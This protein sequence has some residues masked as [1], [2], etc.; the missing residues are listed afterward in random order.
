VAARRIAAQ[1]P[2]PERWHALTAWQLTAAPPGAD[3]GG[4]NPL[5]LVA[6]LFLSLAALVLLLACANLAN[7]LLARG[8]LRR[9][10][11]AVRA[12]MG[13]GRWR[14]LWQLLIESL[15]VSLLGGAAGLLVAFGL[16]Q[17]LNHIPLGS[18]VPLD[19]AG[20]G[21]NLRVFAYGAGLAMLTGLVVGI[22]PA[23]QASR[24]HPQEALRSDTRTASA[25]RSRLRSALVVAEIAGSLALLIV[26]GL[27]T[28]SLA[29]AQRVNLG[30][31]PKSVLNLTFNPRTG[32]EA[33]AQ[34]A[35]FAE[36]LWERAGSLPGVASAALAISTPMGDTQYGGK[37]RIPGAATP[38][39][40]LPT[41]GYNAVTPGYLA[42]LGVP[43]LRGRDLRSGETGVAV[44]NEKM[45]Q[46]FW[47]GE[48]PLGHSFVLDQN[49]PVTLRIVGVAANS[50]T[51]DI[52]DPPGPFAYLPF[53]QQYETPVVLQ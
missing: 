30:F 25:S 34:G 47:P 33:G 17:A 44:V 18:A 13:A 19:L 52:T 43:L 37:V 49:A 29:R 20:V 24:L 42:T 8:A 48:D 2:H 35:R 7:L 3:A 22:A 21:L 36:S 1:S 26:A 39:S 38:R 12:A 14:L 27:F 15:L 10:E 5:H 6:A 41:I 23:L 11:L 50:L 51:G 31:S 9:R 45:A 28:R 16:C 40:G 4:V 46:Q 53:A 32:G